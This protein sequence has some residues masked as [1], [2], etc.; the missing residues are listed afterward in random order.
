MKNIFEHLNKDQIEDLIN[1]YY[2]EKAMDLIEEFNLDVSP[3]SLKKHFPPE[4]VGRPCP[5][6]STGLYRKRLSKSEFQYRSEPKKA[7]CPNCNHIE[8]VTCP[9]TQCEL[10]RF[11]IREEEKKIR[12]EYIKNKYTLDPANY[13][14]FEDLS[15]KGKIVLGAY[16]R[17]GMLENFREIKPLNDFLTKFTPTKILE[18]QY[19]SFLQN[20]NFL[21]VSPHTDD[22]GL[23]ILDLEGKEDILF[24]DYCRYNL[25]IKSR[26]LA[27]DKLIQ[28]IL[29][30]IKP[31]E[32]EL[33]NA[34]LLWQELAIH[35]CI[36]Y[37]WVT[38][39][40]LF[41]KPRVGEKTLTVFGDLVKKFSVAQ[42][43]NIIFSSSNYVLRWQREHQITG[44]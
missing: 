20:H 2:T 18:E 13:P 19:F 14:V 17:E 24:E 34:L 23:L 8:S 11:R 5:H 25:C 28:Q 6:C 7:Y 29:I 36:D 32:D 16:M 31:T 9:C 38:I 12:A 44:Q 27:T 4:E 15:Y 10:H 37:Y 40:R 3:S 22:N 42:I 33:E 30:P 43:Y 26:S 35:E 41:G 1:R 21:E 39:D